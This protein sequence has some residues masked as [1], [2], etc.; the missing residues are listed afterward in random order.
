MEV[1]ENTPNLEVTNESTVNNENTITKVDEVNEVKPEVSNSNENTTLKVEEPKDVVMIPEQ[2]EEPKLEESKETE[3]KPAKKTTKKKQT[4]SK[5]VE[6]AESQ[7]IGRARSKT[8][9]TNTFEQAG[10]NK[11]QVKNESKPVETIGEGRFKNLLSMFDKD[12]KPSES[13]PSTS[14]GSNV[15]LNKI[16][17]DKINM[18]SGSSSTNT[19]SNS[20]TPVLA[21][22]LSS[23]IKDRMENM[24]KLGKEKNT[25]PQ[26]GGGVKDPVLLGYKN[27][28]EDEEMVED[29]AEHDHSD[30]DDLD[31]SDNEAENNEVE[32]KDEDNKEGGEHDLV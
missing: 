12:K 4:S 13:L 29:H 7:P 15:G 20:T 16:N 31:I 5:G 21:T 11:P 8:L 23:S 28:V 26:T 17:N 30:A 32:K 24:L 9:N 3:N 25:L 14:G 22:G 19:N 6:G 2:K 18:F 27:N 1:A 10:K